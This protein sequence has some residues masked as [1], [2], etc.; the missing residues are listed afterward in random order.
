MVTLGTSGK[1]VKKLAITPTCKNPD[2]FFTE[3]RFN[4]SRLLCPKLAVQIDDFSNCK[5]TPKIA[6]SCY[7]Q[8]ITQLRVQVPSR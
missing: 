6:L 8:L 2:S 7:M 4:L 1:V 5:H 3:V